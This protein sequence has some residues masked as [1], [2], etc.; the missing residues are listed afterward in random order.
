MPRR[1][2]WL[3]KSVRCTLLGGGQGKII[4][5]AGSVLSPGYLLSVTVTDKSLHLPLV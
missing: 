1:Y 3:G 4:V 5:W 2:L